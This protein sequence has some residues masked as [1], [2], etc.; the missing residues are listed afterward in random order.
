MRHGR[1]E[2]VAAGLGEGQK[3]RRRHDADRVQ[4]DI[5]GAGIAAAI[6]IEAGYWLDRAGLQGAAQDID[7]RRAAG[8]AF[9]GRLIEHDAL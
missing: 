3:R 4:A 7:R 1:A 8:T 6:A 5:L 9:L 2:I